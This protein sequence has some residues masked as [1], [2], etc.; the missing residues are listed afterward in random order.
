MS[1]KLLITKLNHHVISALIDEKGDFTEINCFNE[2]HS[3]SLGNIYI[4]K[5]K[6]IVKNINAVFIEYANKKMGYYDLRDNSNPI[7]VNKEDSDKICVGDEV[8]V[9]VAKEAVKT[10]D[11]VL[12]SNF[13]VTLNKNGI[14]FS[15]KFNNNEK[16]DVLKE[17]IKE[18]DF[19]NIGVIIRTNAAD[20][21]DHIILDEIGRLKTNLFE[22][23]KTAHYR[24]CYSVLLESPKEYITNIRD[25]YE[26]SFEKIITDDSEIFNNIK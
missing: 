11:P 19:N 12:S 10:K 13:V 8:V 1:G 15:K 9:Q 18:E 20:V 26:Q 17:E 21:E 7:I 3:T 2:H 23:T 16:K 22:I 4:G 25:M 5:V 6:N 24:T 14:S